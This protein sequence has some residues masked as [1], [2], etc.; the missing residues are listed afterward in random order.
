MVTEVGIRMYWLVRD[1]GVV[2][3]WIYSFVKKF[4]MINI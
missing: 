1:L 2:M 4:I 3:I